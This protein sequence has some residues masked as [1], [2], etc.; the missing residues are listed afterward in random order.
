MLC[1]GPASPRGAGWGNPHPWRGR[2]SGEM[3]RERNNDIWG[4]GVDCCTG[5]VTYLALLLI[6]GSTNNSIAPAA[7]D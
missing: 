7:S 6:S 1:G 2:E 5:N 4:E 3:E